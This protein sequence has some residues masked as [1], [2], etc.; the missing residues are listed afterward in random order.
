MRERKRLAAMKR[1][2]REAVS[3]FAADGFDRVTVEQIAAASEVS[4]MSVYRWF[5]TKEALVLWDEFDPPILAEVRARLDHEPPLPAVRNALTALLD[6]VY[7]RERAL[8]LERARLIFAEPALTAG[9]DRNTR[10]LRDELA[11]LFVA[12]TD[13]DGFSAHTCAAVATTLLA[14]AVEQWQHHDGARPL[15]ELIAATF[16]VMEGAA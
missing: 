16:A 5:G 3:R 15:A 11:T 13:L 14:V 8:A 10:A 7:D 1:V 12:H 4:A 9:A 2:Q 6:D